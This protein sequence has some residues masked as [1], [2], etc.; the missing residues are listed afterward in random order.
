MHAVAF[1]AALLYATLTASA[2]PAPSLRPR[3][4]TAISLLN[5]VYLPLHIF[6]V[7]FTFVGYGL[8]RVGNQAFADYVDAQSNSVTH[9]NNEE[10]PDPIL[11]GMFLGFMHPSGDSEVHIEDSGEWAACTSQDNPS[12][13]C[14]VGDVPYLWDG[15]VSDHDGPY[16]GVN[17]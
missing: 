4:S 17:V 3:A 1:S 10:D 16:N 2:K 12:T 8:P 7:T 13:E 14:I 6:N 15:N 9:I 11:P 5:T